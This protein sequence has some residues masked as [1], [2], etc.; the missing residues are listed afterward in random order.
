M[1]GTLREALNE[2]TRREGELNCTQ[3][4]RSAPS[5]SREG[6]SFGRPREKIDAFYLIRATSSKKQR[7]VTS[8]PRPTLNCTFTNTLR[9]SMP[10][11]NM[12][13]QRPPQPSTTAPCK[14]P[15]TLRYGSTSASLQALVH[16]AAHE[17]C[18]R[19]PAIAY[20][21]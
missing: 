11:T 6:R 9:A 13:C 19:Q 1:V 18:H 3:V 16:T 2:C 7:S 5:Q 10:Q 20:R 17:L 14:P 4:R 21:I 12:R 8:L 15:L